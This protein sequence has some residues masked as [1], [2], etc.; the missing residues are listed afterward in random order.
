MQTLSNLF[1]K[2]ESGDRGTVLFTALA[3]NIQKLNDHTHNGTNSE[4]I[5]ASAITKGT[6][7]V[8]ASGWSSDATTGLYRQSITFPGD[9][10]HGNSH[11]RCF[12]NGGTY[13]GLEC[14]PTIEKIT[15]TTAYI[16]SLSNSQA[17]SLVFV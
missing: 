15:S 10:T 14:F 3:D 7:A 8:P 13:D 11:I 17:F 1:K 2:P 9:F 4:P 5:A 12:F 6:L 16:Y